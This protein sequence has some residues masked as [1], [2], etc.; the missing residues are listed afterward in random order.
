MHDAVSYTTTADRSLLFQENRLGRKSDAGA[1]VLE[2]NPEVTFQTIDGFGAAITGASCYN[3]LKMTDKDRHDIL[4]ELFD[5]KDGLGISLIRVSI[6]ASDFSVDEEFTWCDEEGLENFRVAREDEE[7]LFP[8]LREIYA[9]NPDVKIVASPWSC[10]RW[11]KRRSVTDDTPYNSWTSGSLR[12]ECYDDYARYFVRWIETME[13]MGFDIYA[14]TIQNEPLNHGNS[15]SLYMTW[16]EQLDFIKRSLGPAFRDAGISTKILLF[17]H[18]YNYDGIED[19]QDY[20]LNIMADAEASQYVAGSAWHNYNGHYSELEKMQSREPEKDIYFTEASIGTWNYNFPKSLLK[21]FNEIFL[22]TMA[23]GCKGVTLW[24]M[25]LDENRRP[26]RPGG[27]GTCYG[28]LTLGVDSAQ[29]VDR[30]SHYYDIAHASKVIKPGAVRIGMEPAPFDGVDCLAF[31]NADG[32]FASIVSNMSDKP[33][34]LQFG[35]HGPVAG[36][37]AGSIVSVLWK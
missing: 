21:D 6:G 19:Q 33:C 26:F 32:S 31:R 15:M 34:T 12:P 20:A 16:Q 22:Q 30:T 25:M 4:V 8:V 18:N 3:L 2:I 37:P 27:C 13:S 10:P 5:P 17:D 7:Y 29:V 11:M 35:E 36:I 1:T 28:V 23:R 14:M 24:N 9:V